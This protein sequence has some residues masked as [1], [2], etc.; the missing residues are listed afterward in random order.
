MSVIVVAGSNND[1]RFAVIDFTVPASPVNMLTT[2]P[3]LGGCMV[4]CAG[5]LAA[6]GNY[7]GDQVVI[8]DISNPA[9]PAMKGSVNTGLQ[10]I[11]AISFDGPHVLA[12]EL[13][14][15]R[16]VFIDVTNPAAPV[17]KSTFSTAIGSISAIALK[18]ARAVA[19]GPNDAIFVVLDYTNPANPAQSKF[20][21]GTGGVFFGG[22]VTCDLDGTH[23]AVG[24]YSEG[25]IVLFDVSGASPA[26]LGE[27]ASDQAGVSSIS[28]SGNTV[29]ASSTN[30]FTLTLA[31]FQNPASPTGGD[32]PSGLGGGAVVK[33]SGNFLAGGAVNDTTVTLYSVAGTAAT[34]LGTANTMLASIA[35]L[36]FTS[37]VVVTPEPQLGPL[38]ASLAFGAIR[39]NTASPAQTLNL[40]NIGTAPLHITALKTS[41]TQYAAVPNGTL[42]AIAPN[43]TTAVQV[44]FTPTAVQSFPATLTMNTDDAAH[45]AVSIALTGSGGYPHMTVPGPLNFGNVAVCLTHS[46]GATIGNTGPVPLHLSSINVTGA[47]FSVSIASLTVPANGTG[48]IPVTF[49]P[50]AV[51][52]ASATLT[53]L[54]DDPTTP[55]ASVALSGNGTPEPP[56]TISVMPTSINFGAVP[57][58]YFAGIAVQ[59]ANTGPCEDLN[60]TLTVTGAAFVLTTGDP[61]TLPNSNPPIS[62]SIAASGTNSYTVV[63]A[64]T[65]TGGASGLLT[66]TSN[67]PANPTVTVPL[68]GTGVTVSP[69][70]IELILDHSGSM[71]TAITGGTRMTALKDAVQMFAELVIPGTGF[72]MGSVEFD[73]GESVLTPLADFDA[74]Q[75]TAIITDANSLT[76]NTLTSIGGGLQLGQTNLSASAMTRKVA[77]VF[78]DGYENQAP[79]IAAVE[80]GVIAAGT[81]VYSVALGDPAYLSVAALAQLAQSSNG[82]FFQTTD[83]LTLRKQFVE[84]LADAFRQN[85]AADPI[86]NLQQGVPVTVPVNI[87]NCESRISFVV[88]WEDPTAQIQFKVRAPD[89]T[90]F[91][92]GSGGNNRLVRYIQRPGYR[93]LQI[94][95]PPGPVHTI[96]PKQLGQ[97]QMQID[98]VFINGG[99]TR[100]STSVLVEGELEIAAQVQ[101]SVVGVPM[102]LSAILLHAGS[103]VNNAHVAVKLTSP[104]NSLAQLSTPVARHRAAAADTHHIPPAL[105]ILTKTTTKTYEASFEKRE[106]IVQLPA[107]N[108]DGVYH[109][110]VTATGTA[111]GGAFE[112]YWSTSF[113]V[114]PRGKTSAG[115][116]Q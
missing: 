71:S 25:N 46:L 109:A 113:Y 53:F 24:D 115:N 20:V 73:S 45:P 72:A 14:G 106:Y 48:S 52:P 65:A 80:P 19:S 43:Q 29:A 31:N 61:T 103:V 33:A 100:A 16:V 27:F 40:K 101:A 111:C 97:W 116:I 70:A 1:H 102:S 63:F 35:T 32:S 74:A 77:I 34:A 57:L 108:V 37:F 6:V 78:T 76:P 47:G 88:L 7:N 91:G 55:S 67:D 9:A 95:L 8:Y 86:L 39:V 42:A 4:D 107:P 54:S 89:G 81:E 79:M 56:P 30:D 59:V 105:Q 2:A 3:F 11:G 18:G 87:T 44:T 10:G 15:V 114:R 22:A 17:I 41:A 13:N 82:K 96:G 38:P 68:T 112:R 62:D 93:F 26:V 75:Q 58:Q 94:T 21:P 98:P 92:S 12:G 23:A 84:V 85:L 83:P 36:G 5:S 28:I 66:I 69:A 50:T 64:P 99:A 60:V 104:L 49:K 110:E 51:G 90:T